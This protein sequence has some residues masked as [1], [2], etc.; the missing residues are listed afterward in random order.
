MMPPAGTAVNLNVGDANTPNGHAW[1][2][3][4][5]P[6]YS[7]NT[8]DHSQAEIARTF[9]LREFGNGSV[10]GGTGS[11]TAP[12]ATMLS[13]VDIIGYCMD[14]GLTQFSGDAL[15]VNGDANI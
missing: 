7:S 2:A 9:M 6:L 15:E 13:S 3:N 10:N 11:T 12:D 8:M 5:P 14:D 1:T 4:V